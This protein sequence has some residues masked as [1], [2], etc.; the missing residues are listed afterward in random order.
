MIDTF[1]GFHSR[2]ARGSRARRAAAGPFVPG[3]C[4]YCHRPMPT[5]KHATVDHVL[6][7][8]WG[9][10]THPDNLLWCCERCN[11]LKADQPID[12]VPWPCRGYG[13]TVIKNALVTG[14]GF[15][16]AWE[17]LRRLDKPIGVIVFDLLCDWVCAEWE[18]ERFEIVRPGAPR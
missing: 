15:E 10:R 18:I 13:R 7:R 9:G 16:G 2:K 12:E 6:A 4:P 5:A 14:R 11:K 3:P 8:V 1:G 17:L